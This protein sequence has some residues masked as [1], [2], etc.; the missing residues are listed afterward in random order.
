MSENICLG[1]QSLGLGTCIMASPAI[2]MNANFAAK[3]YLD[4]LGFSEGYRL[5][6]VIAVGYPD[7]A[8]EAKP[9]DLSKIKFVD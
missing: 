8:P 9:R 6:V 4:K 2:F 5:Q 7:E 3:P 1:A